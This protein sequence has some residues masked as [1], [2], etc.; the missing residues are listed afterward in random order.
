MPRADTIWRGCGQFVWFLLS[1]GPRPS[2]DVAGLGLAVWGFKLNPKYDG[3]EI[4]STF[5]SDYNLV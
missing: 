2:A 1:I 5:K 3:R 4:F